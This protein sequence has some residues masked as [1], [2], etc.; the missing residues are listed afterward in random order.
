MK[1]ADVFLRLRLKMSFTLLVIL[2]FVMFV[3]FAMLNVYMTFQNQNDA[4]QFLRELDRNAGFSVSRL[5]EEEEL[6]PQG[7]WQ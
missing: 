1:K 3:L 5:R 4:N 2:A 7:F 6:P